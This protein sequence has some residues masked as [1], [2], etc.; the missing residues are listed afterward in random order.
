MCSF[1]SRNI[2]TNSETTAI[3]NNNNIGAQMSKHRHIAIDKQNKMLICGWPRVDPWIPSIAIFSWTILPNK[4]PN[5]VY[6]LHPL[7]IY[8]WLLY[9]CGVDR[10]TVFSVKR[11]STKVKFYGHLCKRFRRLVFFEED[12]KKQPTKE[13]NKKNTREIKSKS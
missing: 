3:G 6:E 12:K 7:P 8:F 4:Q 10:E 13:N 9:Y 11:S 1:K 5:F 2:R